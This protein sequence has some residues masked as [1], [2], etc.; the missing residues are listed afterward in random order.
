MLSTFS[1]LTTAHL[2][3][4]CNIFFG[5]KRNIYYVFCHLGD[6]FLLLAVQGLL[7]QSKLM[8]IAKPE[9]FIF[10]RIPQE[11]VVCKKNIE[12]SQFVELAATAEGQPPS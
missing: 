12:S 7:I 8:C 6:N 3:I 9:T 4:V 11:I 10:P 2:S 5:I 1:N